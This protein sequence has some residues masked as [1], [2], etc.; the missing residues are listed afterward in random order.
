MQRISVWEDQ[1][2]F[3]GQKSKGPFGGGGQD[4]HKASSN[5]ERIKYETGLLFF[6]SISVFTKL[7]RQCA[8]DFLQV[9]MGSLVANTK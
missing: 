3:R 2:H 5:L 9:L 6:T 8:S 7:G 1:R 4:K